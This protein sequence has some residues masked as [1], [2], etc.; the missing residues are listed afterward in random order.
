[1]LKIVLTYKRTILHTFL[2]YDIA[3]Q[4][5]LTND[6]GTPL[7]ELC[8]TD[9]VDSIA[10]RDD[11]IEVVELCHVVLTICSSCRVFLGN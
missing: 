3:T 5:E 4:R 7:A 8:G 10:H 9:G 2:V 11:G 6:I 1:M